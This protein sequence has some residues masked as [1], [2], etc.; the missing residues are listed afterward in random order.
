L[1]Y[2]QSSTTRH[3]Q[4]FCIQLITSSPISTSFRLRRTP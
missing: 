1:S 4:P 2:S 3:C